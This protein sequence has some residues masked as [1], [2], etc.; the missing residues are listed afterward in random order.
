MKLVNISQKGDNG[1]TFSSVQSS[2]SVLSDSLRPHGRQQWD[3]LPC[4]SPTLGAY[5]NSCPSHR[6]CHHWFKA[7]PPFNLCLIIA[8][9]EAVTLI[10]QGA[11]H[12]NIFRAWHFF[13]SSYGFCFEKGWGGSNFNSCLLPGVVWEFRKHVDSMWWTMWCAISRSA[14][15][16][17]S[18]ALAAGMLSIPAFSCQLLRDCWAT[19]S[20]S[21]CWLYPFLE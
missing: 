16:E 13:F 6:W 17:Q 12:Q 2:R 5:S 20:C 15:K 18:T 21:A 11:S 19:I 9:P 14:F 3:Q 4:P 10:L 1:K 8:T 7:K